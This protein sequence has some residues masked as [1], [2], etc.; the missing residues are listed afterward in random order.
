MSNVIP[1]SLTFTN[2]V[3]SIVV[4]VLVEFTGVP[5]IVEVCC[6]AFA[7]PGKLY[8]VTGVTYVVVA[9]PVANTSLVLILSVV[10]LITLSTYPVT[11]P[12]VIMS[13]TLALIVPLNIKI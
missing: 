6:T 11:A 5:L 12:C 1:L 2:P 13:L 9:P 4:I 7:L 8:V 3:F 10:V